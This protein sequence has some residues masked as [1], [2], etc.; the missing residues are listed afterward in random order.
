MGGHNER[1]NIDIVRTVIATI[2]R[3]M[4]EEPGLRSVLKRREPDGR[5]GISIDW[6]TDELITFVR[7]RLGHDRR[8]AI[9]PS[10]IHAELG[11]L[12][13]TT[14]E[15]GIVRTIRWYLTHQDWVEQVASGDY[16]QYYERM[17]GGR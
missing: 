12:P 3:L 8:Y 5:G 1:R 13:T 15:D 4:T 6:M 7:D 16:Q 9:D 11:W 14:F 17:Y 10:K 2:R